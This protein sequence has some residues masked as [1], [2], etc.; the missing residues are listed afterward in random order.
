MD[1]PLSKP[2]NKALP[3]YYTLLGRAY[4]NWRKGSFL[5]RKELKGW[6][7]NWHAAARA[8]N[9]H[10]QRQLPDKLLISPVAVDLLILTAHSHIAFFRHDGNIFAQITAKCCNSSLS[11]IRSSSVIVSSV[12]DEQTRNGPVEGGKKSRV[13][14][15][16]LM[17]VGDVGREKPDITTMT[18]PL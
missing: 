9:P 4:A 1:S 13:L 14:E 17:R 5:L 16:L 8:C 10:A 12:Q 18:S 2:R 15:R 11:E 3:G 7:A 6:R